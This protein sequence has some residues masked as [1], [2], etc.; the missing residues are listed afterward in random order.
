MA[1]LCAAQ[2]LVSTSLWGW[3]VGLSQTLS[4]VILVPS[5]TDSMITPSSRSVL[6]A[7]VALGGFSARAEGVADLSSSLTS[8]GVKTADPR[9]DV[10]PSALSA[11]IPLGNGATKSGVI[12]VSLGR[13]EVKDATDGYVLDSLADGATVALYAGGF[14]LQLQGYYTGW[15][16]KKN[17]RVVVGALDTASA[18]DPSVLWAP[19]RALGALSVGWSEL[20]LRQDLSWESW[21]QVDLRGDPKPVNTAYSTLKLAGPAGPFH[22]STT[23]TLSGLQ[24]SALSAS[25]LA[26]STWSLPLLGGEMSFDG[27][28]ALGLA[29]SEFQALGGRGLAWVTSFSSA[30]GARLGADFSLPLFAGRLG[31]KGDLLLR[32]NGARDPVLAGV[33]PGSTGLL[34]GSEGVVYGSARLSSEF[35]WS[36]SLGVFGPGPD[37]VVAGTPTTWLAALSAT[38]EM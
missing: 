14:S 22:H 37:T 21:V 25:V 26:A 32:T 9:V 31:A 7:S 27:A 20:W 29:D 1:S 36:W 28:F 24:T 2:L 38:L 18:A 13:L 5:A 34:L 19:P 33:L 35:V 12:D 15:V 3:D 11:L 30:N 6:F 17:S 23:V 4:T 16:L 8:L 10:G